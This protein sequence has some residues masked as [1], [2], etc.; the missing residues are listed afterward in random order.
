MCN[1]CFESHNQSTNQRCFN[2][3]CFRNRSTVVKGEIIKLDEDKAYEKLRF[4]CIECEKD[5][6]KF[7]EIQ[8]HLKTCGTTKVK[9]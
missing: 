4:K 5:K 3:K 8:K 9:S 1:F 7:Y 6:M 2:Q